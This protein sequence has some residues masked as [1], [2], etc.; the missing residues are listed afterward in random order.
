MSTPQTT[1]L[2]VALVACALLCG[3]DEDGSRQ[4]L[5]D[6]GYTRIH[7]SGPV[8]F[9]CGRDDAIRNGFDAYTL[10]GQHVEGVVCAG[11]FFK[12]YTVR[13]TGRLANG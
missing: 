3:C 10:T 1:R 11:L 13:I 12:G 4:A 9:G 8:F 2:A 5:E 6:Q 7:M